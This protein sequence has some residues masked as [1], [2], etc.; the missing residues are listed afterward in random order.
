[1]RITGKQFLALKREPERDSYWI[2]R[3]PPGPS[4]ESMR[5]QF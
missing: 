4:P 1:M 3:D 2:V 5:D